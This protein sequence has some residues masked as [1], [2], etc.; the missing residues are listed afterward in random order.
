LSGKPFELAS[1]TRSM[2]PGPPIQTDCN[3]LDERFP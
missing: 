1:E 2:P 3:D